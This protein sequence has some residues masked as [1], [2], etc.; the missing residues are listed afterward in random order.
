MNRCCWLAV[1][2]AVALLL[3][4]HSAADP[5][6][7]HVGYVVPSDRAEQPH[8]AVNMWE[9]ARLAQAWYAEQMDR[10]GLGPKTFQLDSFGATHVVTA[11]ESAASIRSNIWGN[12]I[13][14][15]SVA[16][17]P[18]WTQGEVWFLTSNSHQMQP[19]G[20]VVGG[21]ALGA[22]FGSGSDSGVAMLGGN[23]NP[24]LS[25]ASLQNETPYAGTIVP[26]IG[27]YPLVQDVSQ[28]WF[29]GDTF[30]SVSSS[31]IGAMAHELGH[32]FGLPHVFRNDN[33]FD[34]PLMGNGLRGF[35]GLFFPDQFPDDDTWLSY[36]SALALSTSR[37]FNAGSEFTEDQ[38]PSLSVTTSGTVATIDG[39]LQIDFRATDASGLSAAVLMRNGEVVAEMPLEGSNTRTRIATPYFEAGVAA[40]YELRVYDLQGNLQIQT[41]QITP[42]A[43]GNLAPQPFV[44]LDRTI[45]ARHESFLL[46]VS[47]TID[48]DGSGS[49]LVEWDLDGDGVF[50]TAPSSSL[51]LT[52]SFDSPGIRRVIARLTDGGG[53]TA[54]SSPIAIRVRND[55]GDFNGDGSVDHGD[56][57]GWD[58]SYGDF[59]V[60]YFGAEGTGN[61]RVE[62]GDLLLWQRAFGTSPGMI[63]AAVAVPEASCWA[64]V[65]ILLGG[66]LRGR[67]RVGVS[68]RPR[69]GERSYGGDY[70]R[71][72]SMPCQ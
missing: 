16:G 65:A 59:S 23:A 35:R 37:Y 51:A 25:F 70:A 47:R 52:T 17:L 9:A 28:P 20:S 4:S 19:D 69:S 56:F 68:R 36:A 63:S 40:N 57:L 60:S 5:L 46:D 48:P 29:E 34:G 71:P 44:D 14:A 55:A 11:T 24:Y 26:E 42:Q 38:K 58:Q 3:A 61:G 10:W 12:N 64:L 43:S 27:P 32:A 33:N 22:S 15:A 53:A 72:R 21:T 67:R 45:V 31:L 39:Q 6:T 50:D 62:G 66:A 30:S 41:V 13:D 2:V 18:I 1:A 54:L 49:L 7:I 8:A